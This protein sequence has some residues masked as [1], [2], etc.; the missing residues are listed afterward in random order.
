MP[1][2]LDAVCSVQE[3]DGF[4]SNTAVIVLAATN[5]ADVID[6]ALRRPGRFDRIVAV[7]SCSGPSSCTAHAYVCTNRTQQTSAALPPPSL[8]MLP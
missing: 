5:R 2:V 4:D 7:R 8:C 6:P 1:A 3:M